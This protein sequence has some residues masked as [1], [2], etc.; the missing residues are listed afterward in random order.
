MTADHHEWQGMRISP[1]MCPVTTHGHRYCASRICLLICL[2]VCPCPTQKP[3]AHTQIP[4]CMALLVAQLS[5]AAASLRVLATR[6][7][8]NLTAVSPPSRAAAHK[9][10]EE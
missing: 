10:S 6:N 8:I 3:S 9:V 7:L 4:G 5:S 1:C 2:L